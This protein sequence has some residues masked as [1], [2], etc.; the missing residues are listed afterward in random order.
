MPLIPA[1][2][3]P[4][5]EG[6]LAAIEAILGYV[7]HFRGRVLDKAIRSR[8]PSKT[9][10][11]MRL[12]GCIKP[13][14]L[15]SK[16]AD[17]LEVRPLGWEQ[18]LFQDSIFP[19]KEATLVLLL[20]SLFFQ[21]LGDEPRASSTGEHSASEPRA[22]PWTGAFRPGH[23]AHLFPRTSQMGLHCKENYILNY[24]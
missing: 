14:L 20:V 10:Y 4:R 5:Q 24:R 21:S 7:Q 1:L 17:L 16:D 9:C 8:L 15:S 2:E 18:N 23:L 12:T 13:A 11:I 6:N 19:L 3:R 22:Q